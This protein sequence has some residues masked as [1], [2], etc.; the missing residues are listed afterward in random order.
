M[1]ARHGLAPAQFCEGPAG[2]FDDDDDSYG[3]H[4]EGRGEASVGAQTRGEGGQG[5]SDGC[6]ERAAGGHEVRRDVLR[7]CGGRDCKG[8]E[9]GGVHTGLIVCLIG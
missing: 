2:E 7:V 3:Q 5:S 8:E 1:G 9:S 6:E 4:G